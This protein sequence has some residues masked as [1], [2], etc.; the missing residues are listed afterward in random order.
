MY[1]YCTTTNYRKIYKN[2]HGTI[3]VDEL[4][5]SYHIHHIDGN[6]SNNSP[7]N[8]RAVSPQ[9]HYE[10]HLE[11]GDWSAALYLGSNLELSAL[12]ISELSRKNALK[13]VQDGTHNLLGDHNPSRRLAKEGKHRCQ[14]GKENKRRLEKGIHNFNSEFAKKVQRERVANGTHN[15]LGGETARALFNKRM[16]EGTH[17]NLQVHTCPHCGKV[18]KGPSMKVWHLDN[19]RYNPIFLDSTPPNRI[20]VKCPHCDVIGG[21]RVMK[22]KHFDRCKHC[23]KD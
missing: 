14:G 7:E 18:G 17:Q 11:Q 13:R 19:C 5:R 2:H 6:H 1:I 23:P 9:E 21:P 22:A 3:P 15:L 10:I 12:E 16:L 4:G 20:P 8:L